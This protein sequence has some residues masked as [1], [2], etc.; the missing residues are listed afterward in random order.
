MVQTGNQEPTDLVI[1]AETFYDYEGRGVLSTLPVPL[2]SQSLSLKQGLNTFTG[3]SVLK[4]NYDNVNIT[5]AT[6][7]AMETSHGS[8]QYYSA[9]N[10]IESIHKD[11]IP[12][13][14]GYAH[15]QVVYKNDNTGRVARQG[16]VGENLCFR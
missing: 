5:S 1:G 3:G 14:E 7:A 8:A 12:D 6:A 13:A 11:Y 4:S 16:G 9:N 10:T 2:Q 15:T